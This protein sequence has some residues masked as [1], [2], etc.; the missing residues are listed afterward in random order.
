MKHHE[1]VK[2]VEGAQE[3]NEESLADLMTWC[4]KY[5]YSLSMIKN[6]S[7]QDADDAVQDIMVKVLKKLSTLDRVKSIRAWLIQVTCHYFI[8]QYRKMERREQVGLSGDFGEEIH[9]SPTKDTDVVYN[10]D[11]AKA[12]EQKTVDVDERLIVDDL[13]NKL[14]KPI[15]RQVLYYRLIMKYSA[16][17]TA[18]ALGKSVRTIDRIKSDAVNEFKQICKDSETVVRG[19]LFPSGLMKDKVSGISEN[20]YRITKKSPKFPPTSNPSRIV[21]KAL[22]VVMVML[23]AGALAWGSLP[24]V[25]QPDIDVREDSTKIEM[26]EKPWDKKSTLPQIKRVRESSRNQENDLG[27]KSAADSQNDIEWDKGSWTQTK[28]PSGGIITALHPMPDGS[29]LAGTLLGGISRSTNNGERWVHASEGLGISPSAINAFA[30]KG[31]TV[32]VGTDD[33]LFYLTKNS[34]SWQQLADG[35]ISGVAVIGDTIYIARLG[36]SV[37]FSNND[38]ESWTPFDTGLP[39][40]GYAERLTLFASGTTLFAQTQGRVV[41]GL[42]REESQPQII[43]MGAPRRVFHVKV[44]EKSWTKLTIKENTVES[45]IIKFIVSGEIV[46]AVTASGGL[47]R[48]TDMG[49]SWQ[50]KTP[51]AMQNFNGEFTAVGNTVFYINLVDGRVFQSE[52]AGDSWTMFNANLTNQRILSIAAV[53]ED[54]L[55]VGTPKGVVRSTDGGKTWTKATAGITDTNIGKLVSLGEMLLT[56]TGDGVTKLVDGGDS[57]GLVSE[58]LIPNDLGGVAGSEGFLLW[59]GAK[60]SVSGDKLYVATCDSNTSRWTTGAPGI[61]SLAEDGKSLLPILNIPAFPENI[62]VIDGFAVSG[63]TFYIISRKRLLRGRLE[64]DRWKDLGL[65]VWYPGG[66]AVSGATLC[67]QTEDG[68]IMRSMNEG[69]KWTKVNPLPMSN[70]VVSPPED[71]PQWRFDPQ[72]GSPLF[73]CNL[74]L[75]GETKY[76]V[77]ETIYANNDVLEKVFLSTNGGKTWRSSTA[78]L[79]EGKIKIQLVDG[80]TLFGTNSD[81]IFRLTLGSDSWEKVAPIQHTVVSLAYDGT[82]IY[83]NT[84]KNGIYRFL[85]SE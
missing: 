19:F 12:S 4:I 83:I 30:Q 44:G 43:F 13:L 55:Y 24:S 82:T 17:E 22:D 64:E 66:F 65:R 35:N 21:V 51:E 25:E 54:T 23:C 32:Y 80:T 60:L 31:N 5:V 39:D 2:L 7:K 36:G 14:R 76:G 34:E 38:G 37:L 20:M 45:D 48:S 59:D 10:D 29:L 62:E 47:F 42:T 73:R 85:R 68:K 15:Y 26:V 41:T 1:F 46:Y 3:G 27:E 9:T 81:G 74:Y 52:D 28:G 75:V 16:K 69:D 71:G 33:G 78:G 6:L 18:E 56:V 70:V 77:G 50:R 53:S 57:W 63:E 49:D 61:Y 72:T 84:G 11:H 67:V 40:L 58:G 79:P 8:D